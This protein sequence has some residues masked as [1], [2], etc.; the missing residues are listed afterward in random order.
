MGKRKKIV[1][2]VD[3]GGSH[4][5]AAGL[6]INNFEILSETYSNGTIDNKASKETILNSWAKIIQRS[7]N[8]IKPEIEG[9]CLAMPGPF[10]YL[11]GIGMFKGNDKYESLYKVDVRSGLSK[12]LNFNPEKIHFENDAFSFA[13]GAVLLN[14]VLCARVIGIT[15]GTGFGAAFLIDKSPVIKSELIPEN[16]CLWDKPFKNNIADNYFS[17]RW[18][19]ERFKELS[20]QNCINVKQIVELN[21]KYTKQVFEE[22][23]INLSEFLNPHLSKFETEAL[24]IGGN[25]SKSHHL[26]MPTLITYLEQNNKV[27]IKIV[28]DTEKCNMLGSAYLINS[29]Y[30]DDKDHLKTIF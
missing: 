9:I 20:G 5:T 22:F 23:A 8:L 26:F 4:I 3:V 28:E 24:I 17:T 18:F 1:L 15:L 19:V 13:T 11:N 7:L 29:N 21:N 30:W 2:G 12:L 6:D 16:G 10:D 27:Q 25:I 14:N